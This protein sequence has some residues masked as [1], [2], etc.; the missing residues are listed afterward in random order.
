MVLEAQ[1]S[2]KRQSSD[3]E[4][5]D[6]IAWQIGCYANFAGQANV[7]PAT[8]CAFSIHVARSGIDSRV[9]GGK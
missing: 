7:M 8:N 1:R 4:R 2:S 6:P 3:I 5:P 9:N